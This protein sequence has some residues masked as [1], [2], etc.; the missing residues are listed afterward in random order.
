MSL[1]LWF[2][3]HQITDYQ[4]R[5]KILNE[6]VQNALC[7]FFADAACLQCSLLV[8]CVI[9]FRATEFWPGSRTF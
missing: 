2:Y 9:R 1:V 4:T 6:T 7:I 8:E 5:D 3:L